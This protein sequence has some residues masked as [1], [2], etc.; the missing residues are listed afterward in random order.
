M[1][2]VCR[3]IPGSQ[4][5]D[6]S[7][8]RLQKLSLILLIV[9]NKRIQLFFHKFPTHILLAD[10]FQNFPETGVFDTEHPGLQVLTY[11]DFHRVPCV[12]IGLSESFISILRPRHAYGRPVSCF[13]TDLPLYG[14]KIIS[15]DLLIPGPLQDTLKGAVV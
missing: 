10:F 8:Q 2:R 12:L 9:F 4:I 7:L 13:F 15:P 5:V 11:G 1:Q 14:F 3:H 6:Q